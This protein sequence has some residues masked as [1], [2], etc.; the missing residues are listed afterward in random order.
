M[1][2]LPTSSERTESALA[3]ART[4]AAGYADAGKWDLAYRVLLSGVGSAQRANRGGQLATAL[5]GLWTLPG[6][7]AT[8]LGGSAAIAAAVARTKSKSQA[9]PA[10][11]RKSAKYTPRW[12]TRGKST[13]DVGSPATSVPDSSAPTARRFRRRPRATPAV[14]TGP[15][16]TTTE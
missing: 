2:R 10:K 15:D 4:R 14:I 8:V 9:K 5:A 1:T 7:K 11:S 16:V 6:A 13:T 3:A 12:T